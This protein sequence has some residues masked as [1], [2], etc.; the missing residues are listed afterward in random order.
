MVPLASIGIFTFWK[1]SERGSFCRVT[2]SAG[3]SFWDA[4][5]QEIPTW[6]AVS[7]LREISAIAGPV[8]LNPEKARNGLRLSG[9][10]G[11][12]TERFGPGEASDI[13][14]SAETV[15]FRNGSL[16]ANVNYYD[17]SG[18]SITVN[19]DQLVLDGEGDPGGFGGITAASF[20][21]PVFGNP[22]IPPPFDPANPELTYADAGSI[23][24]NAT[25]D[26]GLTVRG[27]AS[28]NGESRSFGQG[29]DITINASD[30]FLARDGMPFGSIASQ[31]AYAGDA[32]YIQ[33]HATGDIQMQE[34]FEI[35]GST[36]GTGNAGTVTVVS[37]NAIDISGENSGIASATVDPPPEVED[38]LA[39]LFG[40]PDFDT[41][42][43]LLMDFGLVD[44]EADMFDVLGALQ[45][46]G[47]IDLGD[48]DP[49]AGDAGGVS[50][51][52]NSLT[53]SGL[54]RITSSTTHDGAGGPVNIDVGSLTVLDGA[55]IR[56]RSGLVSV[57][58]DELEA[59]S[60]NGGVINI[61][62]DGKATISG[63][64]DDG[65]PSS[66]STSTLGEGNGGNIILT[67]NNVNLNNGGT[68]SASSTGTGLAGD[69]FINAGKKF[70]SEGGR[71]T[72][73]AT[74][75]DGGN[76][77]L[78]AKDMVNLDKAEITTSVESGLGGGGNIDI[79]P[80][81][82]ILN[83]S[84]ILAN[85]FGGPG[86]N[87]NIVAGNFIVSPDSVI[88]AS[89]ERGIDGT[90]N[91]SSPDEEVSEDLAVLPE[92]FLDVTGL[93]SER[94]GATAGAS[95]L[96][97]AGPGGMAVDPDGY[98]PS[99]ALETNQEAE[100]KGGSRTVSSG[101]RWWAMEMNKTALLPLA[102]VTCTQ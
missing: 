98:L 80:D 13:N 8:T 62:V 96:V 30:I 48:P 10:A 12:I 53:M 101:E 33:I 59:G 38:S 7:D 84:K 28:I 100:I 70:E 4:S 35:S 65:S 74:V 45:M 85:A 88:D 34:G 69:I 94:C 55:E 50:V 41:L 99:F 3:K 26:G 95:S 25:G 97:D 46:L 22:D 56:S 68:I 93:I 102:M 54:G 14:V 16:I 20:F 52:A 36:A 76:I 40:L 57:I 9:F 75:S 42:V 23:T 91:I 51:T 67:A 43:A 60:G 61:D 2:W 17:G 58:T 64:G 6:P 89:S 19:A 5:R 71:V 66:I 21:S 92:N 1:S 90:V 86:G 72:T 32:G 81:F 77:R 37:D 39:Q 31:S 78:T 83:Q 44:A 49:T 11:V 63:Q 29:A 87:I 18:G 73:Q 27:G 47:F 79:D 82:V 15:E 24:I